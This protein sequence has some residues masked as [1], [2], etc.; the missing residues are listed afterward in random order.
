MLTGG[1]EHRA[2]KYLNNVIEQDHRAIKRRVKASGHFRA[3]GSAAAT[4]A[5]YEA[6]HVL[7]KGQIAA[8][9]AGDVPAQ[10]RFIEELFGIAA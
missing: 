3:F 5:G 10:N 2:V 7:R 4:L 8:A 1:C 9:P 6:M